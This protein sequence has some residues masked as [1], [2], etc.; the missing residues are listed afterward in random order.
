MTDPSPVRSDRDEDHRPYPKLVVR[1]MGACFQHRALPE[2]LTTEREMIA[3]A[4]YTSWELGLK[5]CLVLAPDR[6][7][8]CEPDGTVTLSDQP[9]SGAIVVGEDAT[10]ICKGGTVRKGSPHGPIV[11]RAPSDTPES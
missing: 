9:P 10:F 2:N 5:T 11:D 6:A 3:H 8:Y 1:L 7:W 4:S